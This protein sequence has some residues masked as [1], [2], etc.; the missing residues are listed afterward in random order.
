VGRWAA[1]QALASGAHV[2]VLDAELHKLREVN[3]EF[4]GQAVTMLTSMRRL[5]RYTAIADVVIGAVLLPGERAPFLV[6][7]TMVKAM[8][9]GSVILDIS[10]D[11][12]GCVETSRPTTIEDP[13]FRE[14]QVLHYCVPN[15]TANVPRTAT[16]VLGNAALPYI[17]AIANSGLEQALRVDA[18]L[19]AGVYAYGGS[20]VNT[21][22]AKALGI[23]AAPLDK[24]LHE[25]PRT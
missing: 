1:R 12:G 19:A 3:H 16:R 6:T 23:E 13:V 20:M 21:K 17:L 15:M 9:P 7:E 18:G 5:E 22:V 14:H 11:Q 2:I 25:G 24:L 8:K 10:I 4:G